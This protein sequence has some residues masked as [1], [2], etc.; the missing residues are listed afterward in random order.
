MKA[1]KARI[2]GFTTG[3]RQW[4]DAA[5]ESEEFDP[6]LVEQLHGALGELAKESRAVT[7]VSGGRVNLGLGEGAADDVGVASAARALAEGMTA[8]QPHWAGMSQGGGVD[9]GG[10]EKDSAFRAQP[11][12]LAEAAIRVADVLGEDPDEADLEALLDEL[13]PAVYNPW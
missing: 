4:R 13:D 5:R 1:L 3:S 9:E 2:R 6:G 11:E 12:A 7:R 8:L 10:A